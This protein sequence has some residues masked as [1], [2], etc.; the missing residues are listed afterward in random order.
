TVRAAA[1]GAAAVATLRTAAPAEQAAELAVEVAPQLVEVG[2]AVV[3][4]AVLEQRDTGRAGRRAPPRRAAPRCGEPGATGG[5]DVAKA[6]AAIVRQGGR[7]HG[8]I[9]RKSTRLNSSHDQIS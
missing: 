8:R 2:R 9:D 3:A 5:A 7:G 4:A 6:H 1:G